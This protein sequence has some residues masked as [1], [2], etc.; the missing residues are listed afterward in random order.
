ML[1]LANMFIGS[2][3]HFD[4]SYPYEIHVKSPFFAC[5]MMKFQ[6]FPMVFPICVGEIIMNHWISAICLGKTMVFPWVFPSK[7]PKNFPRDR[8]ETRRSSKGHSLWASLRGSFW[9]LPRRCHAIVILVNSGEQWFI[10]ILIVVF[11]GYKPTTLW[12]YDGVEKKQQYRMVPPA[13]IAFS[14]CVYSSNFTRVFVGNIS[15]QFSWDYKPTNITWG[16]PPCGMLTQ[17]RNLGIIWNS[18]GDN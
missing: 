17:S 16:A 10:V 18:Q 8:D 3:L 11:I 4:R 6:A 14:W 13:T 5:E 9:K 12:E 2:I 1:A 15:N 7:N